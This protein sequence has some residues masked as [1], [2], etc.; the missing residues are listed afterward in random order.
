MREQQHPVA[1]DEILKAIDRLKSIWF[2]DIFERLVGE[3]IHRSA[4]SI[5]RL[6]CRASSA[7]CLHWSTVT[8]AHDRFPCRNR[9][10]RSRKVAPGVIDGHAD[11]RKDWVKFEALLEACVL[12]CRV[13]Y[14][15]SME[16]P[17][18]FGGF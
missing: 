14:Q 10:R 4:M 3:N 8:R 13:L 6:E 15:F 1:L 7:K 9:C 12:V 2:V 18:E 17:M 11:L 16:I 5:R